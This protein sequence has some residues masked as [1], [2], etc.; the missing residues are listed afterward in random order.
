MHETMVLKKQILFLFDATLRRRLRVARTLMLLLTWLAVA[1]GCMG[2]LSTSTPPIETPTA[3]PTP[4]LPLPTPLPSRPSYEPGALVD[5]TAQSGDNLPALAARFN[6]TIE[7]IRAANP[8]IPDSATTMP[9]GMPMQI[10]IYYRP[11]WGTPYQILADSLFVNGPAQ[12]GF[13]PVA[14]VDS[15]PGWLKNYVTYV[16]DRNRRGG[17]IV[18]YVSTNYSVSPRL[19]L[20]LAEY[21]SGALSNPNPPGTI[22]PLGKRDFRREGFYRQLA[23]AADVLNDAYY[24]WRS[25]SLLAFEHL[26]GRLERP[27]PWQNAATVA[28]QYYF[29][30]IVDGD[31]YTRAVSGVGIAETYRVLFGEPMEGVPAHIPGSLQQPHFRLPF[32]PGFAWAY[33]GGPHNPWGEEDGPLA[34]IDFAPPA[35]VGGCT[36]TEEWAAAM[37]PGVISRTGIGIA[38]LDLDGDGDERTGWVIFYL[39]LETATIPPVGTQLSAGDPIGR[40]SCEGGKSTGTHVHIARKYNGEWMLAAGTMAFTMEDWVVSNGAEP[41]LGYLSRPGRT[42]SACVCSDQGSHIQSQEAISLPQI[43]Q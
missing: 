24:N 41:Y 42:V 40:P 30:G 14:F 29:A 32:E 23:W 6:T 17:E 34:A 4:T 18:A 7:E 15:Q 21:Q 1:S 20:A 10:P 22:Y 43:G 9:P 37:A 11:L 38:V 25:G 27:D 39:H 26:D 16:G 5:Y 33:T 13:D 8:I 28:L 31:A 19:L 35:V 2:D 3:I 12:Q 36:A